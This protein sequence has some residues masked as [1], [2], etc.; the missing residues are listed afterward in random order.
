MSAG[1]HQEGV[2]RVRERKATR[3][4]ALCALWKPGQRTQTSKEW[5]SQQRDERGARWSFHGMQHEKQSADGYVEQ[6]N[7][8]SFGFS[9]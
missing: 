3:T 7:K 5:E 4:P 9:G 8:G 2:G 6:K 1:K